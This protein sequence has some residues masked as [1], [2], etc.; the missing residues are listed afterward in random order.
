M[1]SNP[2]QSF[3]DGRARVMAYA[4]VTIRGDTLDPEFWT[5]YF[6]VA[7]DTSTRK[8]QL[9]KTSS[10]RLSRTPSLSGVWGISS[11]PAVTCVRLDAHVRYLIETLRLPREDL[12]TL[13][14]RLSERMRFFCYWVSENG[15]RL[16][17][18]DF[19]LR[20]LIEASGA[21]LEID[22]YP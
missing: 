22:Q 8:G 13:L 5:S 10:G 3:D 4:S 1:T 2:K 11:H 12:S 7:P 15:T 9:F 14:A 18:I 16:P 17:E 19:E 20:S 21:S 6:E